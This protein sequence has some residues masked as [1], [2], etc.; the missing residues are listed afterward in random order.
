MPES[1]QTFVHGLESQYAFAQ[2]IHAVSCAGHEGH[3]S[4]HALGTEDTPMNAVS[5]PASSALSASEHP[6][7]MSREARTPHWDEQSPTRP[8]HWLACSQTV[9]QSVPSA[10][11]VP[12]QVTRGAADRRKS[13]AER[14]RLRTFMAKFDEA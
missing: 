6:A 7:A 11:V 12:P 3:R 1:W 13:I 14:V 5:R 9:W 8:R 2:A 4:L 10:T